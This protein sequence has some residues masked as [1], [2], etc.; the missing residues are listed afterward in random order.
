M[1]MEQT[2]VV[3]NDFEIT[4]LD[5]AVHVYD[6]AKRQNDEKRF[7]LCVLAS[8]ASQTVIHDGEVNLL[9]GVVTLASIIALIMNGI[10]LYKTRKVCENHPSKYLNAA[11]H[12]WDY[13]SL[14]EMA[15]AYFKSNSIFY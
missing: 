13:D 7:Q 2:I 11:L 9:S 8:T 15:T 12:G 5:F 10:S 1:K 3:N 6:R 14:E 4:P